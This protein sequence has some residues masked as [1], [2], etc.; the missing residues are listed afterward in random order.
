VYVNKYSVITSLERYGY[1]VQLGS[2]EIYDTTPTHVMLIENA[3]HSILGE[4]PRPL[5]LSRTYEPDPAYNIPDG[6]L[7]ALTTAHEV[8]RGLLRHG[9]A[10]LEDCGTKTRIKIT[11]AGGGKGACKLTIF[12]Y[13]SGDIE[14]TMKI[15]REWETEHVLTSRNILTFIDD[16]FDLYRLGV[17]SPV[18]LQ[19]AQNGKPIMELSGL[20]GGWLSGFKE[21]ADVLRYAAKGINYEAV[22]AL[23]S[24]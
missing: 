11:L 22:V 4:V 9:Q 12:E 18:S 1:K 23:A 10:T 6:F 7:T 19:V 16:P 20:Q 14:T 17:K 21:A 13:R 2:R 3:L 15:H 8:I 5:D 24:P